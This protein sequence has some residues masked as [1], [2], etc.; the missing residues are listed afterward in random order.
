MRISPGDVRLQRSGRLQQRKRT[1]ERRHRYSENSSN[2]RNP[3]DYLDRKSVDYR[4]HS[5]VHS[6]AFRR[7]FRCPRPQRPKESC[8]LAGPFLAHVL[9]RVMSRRVVC[10]R[11]VTTNLAAFPGMRVLPRTVNLGCLGDPRN[12]PYFME[13]QLCRGVLAAAASVADG[14]SNASESRRKPLRPRAQIGSPV[15]DASDRGKATVSAACG[16]RQKG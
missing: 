4:D 8:G 13:G 9:D 14:S 16:M 11:S 15:S 7:W 10:C 12:F 3:M 1:G 5:H 2:R 6:G